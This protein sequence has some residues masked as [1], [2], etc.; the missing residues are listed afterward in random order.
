MIERTAA[1]MKD[2]EELIKKKAEGESIHYAFAL[3]MSERHKISYP[4]IDRDEKKV[5]A[6]L[7]PRIRQIREDRGK[8]KNPAKPE[9]VAIV[10]ELVQ[11]GYSIQ[12]AVKK[13][14]GITDEP[15]GKRLETKISNKMKEENSGANTNNE[16]S[17]AMPANE[18]ELS[19]FGDEFG[20]F[21][22]EHFKLD[23]IAPGKGI[24]IDLGEHSFIMRKE[25]IND[26]ILNLKNAHD[27]YNTENKLGLS[28]DELIKSRI[29]NLLMLQLRYA[30]QTTDYK[31]IYSLIKQWDMMRDKE[32]ELSDNF[33]TFEK[34]LDEVCTVN[35]L[36]LYS[37]DEKIALA[38]KNSTD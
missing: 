15:I 24:K 32:L 2:L 1:Y 37:I 36:P 9:H 7:D 14:A 8:E 3:K 27:D 16:S 30:G 5:I 28:I 31:R 19:L 34:V 13:A 6:G 22:K 38:R 17:P 26:I 18:M 20:K 12:D 33:K 35:N 11:S 23:M 4:T 10:S 29:R 25:F 21:L